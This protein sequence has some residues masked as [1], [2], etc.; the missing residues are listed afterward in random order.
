MVRIDISPEPRVVKYQL[1]EREYIYAD[2]WRN[3]D[4]DQRAENVLLKKYFKRYF[5]G[6]QKPTCLVDIAGSFGRLLP[7]YASYFKEVAILDYAVNEFHAAQLTAAQQQL[8]LYL[9]AANAYHI[10]LQDNSQPALITVRLVHHL[11]NPAWFL[12]EV[13]RVLQP[14]GLFIFQASNKNNLLT[15]VQALFKFDFSIWKLD[16]L[17]LGQ[18]GMQEDGYF[19]LIR[20]YRAGYLEQLIKE[21]NLKIVRKRSVSWLRRLSFVRRYPKFSHFLERCFQLISCVLPFGP[22]NWYVIRKP[23]DKQVATKQSVPFDFL[24]TLQSPNTKRPLT[25]TQLTRFLKKTK[26][27]ASYLS[28]RYPPN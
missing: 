19:S 14:G 27:G 1:K 17:D 28:L 26:K 18:K 4:Y 20:T 6:K 16:W 25:K 8:K 22:S 24:T 11:E 7:V 13:A 23:A 10:P 12:K 15:L 9:I 5:T 3:R 21:Q 2:F